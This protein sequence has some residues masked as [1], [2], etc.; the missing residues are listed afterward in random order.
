MEG[1]LSPKTGKSIK[2]AKK[3]REGE[4]CAIKKNNKLLLR[5]ELVLWAMCPSRKGQ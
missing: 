4:V 5:N 1:E 3:Q 2:K